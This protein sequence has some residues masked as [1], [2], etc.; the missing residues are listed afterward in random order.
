MENHPWFKDWF[1]S[2]YYH[3]LYF[4]R[5]EKEAAAFIDKLINHLQPA[6]A[7]RMLDVACGKGRHSIHLAEKGFDVTGIDLSEDSI[8]EALQFQNETLHFYRHD[9]RLPFWI[10]YFN[11]AFNFFTS[12]G[13]FKTRREHDN[14]IRTIAQ[15]LKPNG[16][17]VM[18]YLNA[19]YAEDNL[20][21]RFEKE[22]DGVNYFITKWFDETHFYKKIQVED[23][24]LAEPLIYTEKVAKFS[25]GDF[26]EMFAYQGLQIQ[27]VFGDYNF[28]GYDV[29]KSPRLIMVAKKG[30]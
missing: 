30:R 22:I 18:D 4:N 11:Y 12:F 28:A 23:E 27:E 6:A 25:L 13:Y 16:T 9:M 17:F 26:T 2:P 24:A 3:Q 1:N 15:S 5:D 14:A 29:N 7:A 19:H 21:H 8:E 20:V 10:N